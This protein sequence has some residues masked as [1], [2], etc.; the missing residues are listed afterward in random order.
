MRLHKFLKIIK[1]LSKYDNGKSKK[2]IGMG[3][4]F[5]I[6]IDP[7]VVSTEDI[8]KLAKLGI[9]VKEDYFYGKLDQNSQHIYQ[10]R[11]H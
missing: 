10:L 1:I 6:N 7:A 8:E 2:F 4:G 3:K 9:E 11:E 5:K